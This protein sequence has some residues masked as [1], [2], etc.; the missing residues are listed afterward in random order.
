M[1]HAP[2]RRVRILVVSP[3]EQSIPYL[4]PV[5]RCTTLALNALKIALNKEGDYVSHGINTVFHAPAKV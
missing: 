1:R 4:L 5:T 3:A 2:H